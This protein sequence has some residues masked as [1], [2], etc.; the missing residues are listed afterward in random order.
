MAC[1]VK[2]P[3]SVLPGCSSIQTDLVVEV[4]KRHC[5][6]LVLVLVLLISGGRFRSTLD[7]FVAVRPQ[8]TLFDPH[9]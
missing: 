3:L 6:H 9:Y 1:L 8:L 7:R 2:T 5:V 4:L